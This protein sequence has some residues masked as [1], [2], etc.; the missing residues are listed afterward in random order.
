MAE[1]VQIRSPGSQSRAPPLSPTQLITDELSLHNS[2]ISGVLRKM[3]GNEESSQDPQLGLRRLNSQLEAFREA[4]RK[5][6]VLTT[7]K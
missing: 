5:R 7:C 1:S 4:S 2:S 3:G 6:A